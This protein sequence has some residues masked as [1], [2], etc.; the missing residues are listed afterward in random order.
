M[1]PLNAPWT[2]DGPGGE[3]SV[4]AFDQDH[5]GVR[6]LGFRFGDPQH[7]GVG[8]CSDVVGLPPASMHALRD[9]DV[10]IV[11]ALRDTPH[12]THAS[13]SQ[14][15]AWIEE[16]RPRRA[17]LTNLHHDLD[18]ADLASRLPAGVEPAFDGMTLHNDVASPLSSDNVY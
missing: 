9:L 17:I 11:D 16:L 15:L 10:F 8:Y 3:L 5:G 12:P 14:A 13:V 6:S 18:Y 4:I 2:V 7:G 1:P